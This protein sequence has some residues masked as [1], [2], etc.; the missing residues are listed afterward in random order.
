M[1]IQNGAV[2][3]Q[4]KEKEHED[5]R[6]PKGEIRQIRAGL[7]YDM[8]LTAKMWQSSGRVVKSASFALLETAKEFSDVFFSNDPLI[9]SKCFQILFQFGRKTLVLCY[10]LDLLDAI[11]GI[12][13]HHQPIVTGRYV[14]TV[15]FSLLLVMLNRVL[16]VCKKL[17]LLLFVHDLE[18]S[19][20]NERTKN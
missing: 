8:K 2:F 12:K 1:K 10:G 11:Q 14:D 17:D 7:M 20:I 16:I 6:Q 9:I 13:R 19:Y 3:R 15:I 4:L 18:R 5:N